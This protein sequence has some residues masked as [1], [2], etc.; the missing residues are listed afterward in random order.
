M[1]RP[2]NAIPSIT[3]LMTSA[4]FFGSMYSGPSWGP[5]R[6]ILKVAFGIMLDEEE[7]GFFQLVAGGRPLPA[8]RCR[9]LI[10]CAGRRDRGAD[11]R[12]FRYDI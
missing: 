7:L 6:A 12:L 3:Q 4:R 11:L 9:E 5:W 1:K 2:T 8:K 10:I